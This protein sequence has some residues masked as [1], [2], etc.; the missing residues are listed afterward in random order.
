MEKE[1]TIL[2]CAH[3]RGPDDVVAATSYADATALCDEIN[4][5]AKKVAHLDVMCVAYPAVW[6][7]DEA[8]HTASL[9]TGNGYRGPMRKGQTNA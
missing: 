7:W 8:S 1:T 9:A 5:V 2:W 6:P 4:G 3:V